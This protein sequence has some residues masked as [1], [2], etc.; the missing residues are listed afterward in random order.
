M[1][2]LEI[3]SGADLVTDVSLILNFI[4]NG[5]QYWTACTLLTMLSPYM[6]AYA[7]LG[8]LLKNKGVFASAKTKFI[9]YIYITPLS[10]LMMVGLDIVFILFTLLSSLITIVTFGKLSLTTDLN[11]G[12]DTLLQVLYMYTYIYIR[13]YVRPYLCTY[14]YSVVSIC[15]QWK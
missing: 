10:F 5:H 3:I 7:A 12:F 1:L 2:I 8:S 15:L 9:G 14:V 13:T 6:I 4:R 11:E